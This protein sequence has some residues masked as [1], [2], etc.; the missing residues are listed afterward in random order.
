MLESNTTSVGIGKITNQFETYTGNNQFSETK[1]FETKNLTNFDATS[2]RYK[3]VS[4][5]DGKSSE[6]LLA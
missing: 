6:A 3:D 1:A 4:L 2:S 5:E